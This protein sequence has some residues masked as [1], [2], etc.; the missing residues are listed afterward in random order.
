MR[1]WDGVVGVGGGQL[2]V[3]VAGPLG[4]AA[5]ACAQAVPPGGGSSWGS[6]SAAQMGAP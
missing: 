3:R 4:V 2:C 5:E 1:V 6:W